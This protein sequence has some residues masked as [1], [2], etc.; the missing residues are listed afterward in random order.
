MIRRSATTATTMRTAVTG[1]MP[2]GNRSR[3]FGRT[4]ITAASIGTA[5]P[6]SAFD[7]AQ[8]FCLSPFLR[9]SYGQREKRQV[10]PTPRHAPKAAETCTRIARLNP[11][12]E[13]H[14]TVEG[15]H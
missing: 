10:T 13:Q 4:S 15:L 12:L 5:S 9:R 3:S 2:I 1:A 11:V 7:D 8:L 6:G 14:Q